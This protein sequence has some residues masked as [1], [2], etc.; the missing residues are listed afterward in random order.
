MGYEFNPQMC[1]KI[2]AKNS[3]IRSQGKPKDKR[4][5]W[6]FAMG[7]LHCTF[8]SGGSAFGNPDTIL[9]VFLSNFSASKILVGLSS[10]MFGSLGGIASILPQIFVASRLENKV[11]KRP[12]LRI[13]I[14][15]RALCWALLS[16]I[17]YLFAS[18]QPNITVISLFFLLTL[19][20]IMGGS[21]D[22]EI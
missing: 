12:L 14:T 6:N 20:T 4:L 22:R 13:A 1:D 10:S 3:I 21:I 2:K 17:T 8:F 15:I 19:F 9:S 7:I 16:L 18:S 5:I 11:Y